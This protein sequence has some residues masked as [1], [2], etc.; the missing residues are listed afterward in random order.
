MSLI[1][2]ND[3]AASPKGYFLKPAIPVI[4]RAIFPLGKDLNG[5]HFMHVRFWR[6]KLEKVVVYASLNCAY[7]PLPHKVLIVTNHC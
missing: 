2:A 7:Q 1:A 6:M 5:F 4:P 3:S